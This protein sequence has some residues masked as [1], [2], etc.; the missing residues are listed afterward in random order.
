MSLNK[1]KITLICGFIVIL[2]TST[3][4]QTKADAKSTVEKFYKFYA[5]RNG[6]VSTHELNLIKPWFT[7][8][9]TKLFQTEIKRE[10]AFTK[11]NTTDKP[12]FGDGFPFNPYEE[13]VVDDKVILNSVE[14][15]EV[16]IDAN[17]AMVEVKFIEPKE[18]GG[19]PIETYKIEL[20]K[21]K[22]RWLINDW[23][24]A[25]ETKLTD[26]LNRKDY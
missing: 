25:D 7:T 11:K 10:A 14:I 8:D 21:S 18:C 20:L 24:Y 2:F 13:C 19:K 4:A 6:V 9:L 15:G 12:H 23:I 16:K 3:F 5:T 17:N 1:L 22:K 26:D